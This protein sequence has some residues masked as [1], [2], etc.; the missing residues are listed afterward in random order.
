MGVVHKAED[1]KLGGAAALKFL[2]PE[3]TRDR[4][5]RKRFV[6]EAQ[7]AS[8]AELPNMCPIHEIADTP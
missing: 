6:C 2:A 8:S 7:A 4:K 1:M 5:A 3:L